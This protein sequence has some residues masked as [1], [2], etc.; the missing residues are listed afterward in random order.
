MS[1]KCCCSNYN[2]S[3]CNGMNY[4]CCGGFN[5]YG[6]GNCGYG[7]GSGFGNNPLFSPL[8]LILLLSRGCF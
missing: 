1:R 7:C 4:N 6:F 3:N 8:I 2:C 5:N